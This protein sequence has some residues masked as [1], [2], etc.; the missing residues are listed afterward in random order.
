MPGKYI[1]KKEEQKTEHENLL[2]IQLLKQSIKNNMR[3]ETAVPL[4]DPGTR[5]DR[6]KRFMLHLYLEHNGRQEE[7]IVNPEERISAGSGADCKIRLEGSGIP[8]RQ[9]EFFG[10]HG[11]VYIKN[12]NP[13]NNTCLKRKHKTVRVDGTG[14]RLC[15][16]DK[17]IAGSCCIRAELLDMTGRVVQ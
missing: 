1:K 7:Y 6:N 17:I 9:C 15:T 12:L 13:M 3:E 8:A 16:G 10:Y 2:R 14:I 4:D 11:D 5:L